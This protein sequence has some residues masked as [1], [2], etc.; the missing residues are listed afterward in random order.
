MLRFGDC[1]LEP[2]YGD[3]IRNWDTPWDFYYETRGLSHRASL[4]NELAL[5]VHKGA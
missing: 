1:Y 2:E 3:L 5:T 4:L